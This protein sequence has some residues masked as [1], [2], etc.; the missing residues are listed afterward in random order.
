MNPLHGMGD[1]HDIIKLQILRD[2]RGASASP[3]EGK[4]ALSGQE[5]GANRL[6][7]ADDLEL[8]DVHVP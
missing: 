1:V 7:F 4:K 6:L 5:G 3:I 8:G 2:A